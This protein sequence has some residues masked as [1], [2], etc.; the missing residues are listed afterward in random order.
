M[1]DAQARPDGDA[2]VGSRRPVRGTYIPM[3]R[4]AILRLLGTGRWVHEERFIKLIALQQ[5]LWAGS[6]AR[7]ADLDGHHETSRIPSNSERKCN[8]KAAVHF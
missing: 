3:G 1:R 7:A 8:R 5:H 2:D 4:S 6:F